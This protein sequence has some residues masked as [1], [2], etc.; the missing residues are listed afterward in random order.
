MK[1]KDLVSIILPVFNGE[2]QIAEAIQSVIGQTYDNWEL[3][4]I[5]DGSTDG[6]AEIVLSMAKK[7][8]RIK[9]VK[10][11]FQKGVPGGLNTGLKLAQ[12]KYIARMDHDDKMVKDRLEIQTSFFKENPNVAVCGGNIR[13]FG[14][15]N[16]RVSNYPITDKEIK[17]TILFENPFAHP[18]VMFNK[19]AFKGNEKDLSYDYNS[20]AVEDLELWL[21]LI[22]KRYKFGNVK[23]VILNY[24]IHREQKSITDD[25]ERKKENEIKKILRRY[26]TFINIKP[27]EKE[28]AIQYDLW[29]SIFPEEK[30]D[31]MHM[32]HWMEKLNITVSSVGE[33]K[34]I[35]PGY[36][37]KYIALR[38]FNLCGKIA[39][40][41]KGETFSL[42]RSRGFKNQFKYGKLTTV[43][44]LSMCL[45]NILI[46]KGSYK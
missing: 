10:N 3:I 8:S 37:E 12:G 14:D 5:N 26:L 19:E 2:K 32:L 33:Q 24:R 16:G 36:F 40:S 28:L 13:L 21:R 18:T 25:K 11:V 45:L 27:T 44:F 23:D 17:A 34:Q 41:L 15:I 9:L 35:S 1:G 39:Y 29:R 20:K 6:T 38:T 22:E 43:K 46:G 30:E 4:I 7:D 42:Y 31:V